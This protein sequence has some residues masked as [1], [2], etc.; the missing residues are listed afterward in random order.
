MSLAANYNAVLTVT[1]ET[2]A[3]TED[4]TP[5]YTES[6]VAVTGW[7][8]ELEVRTVDEPFRDQSIPFSDRRALFMCDAGSD[9]QQDDTGTVVIGG[10]D[11]GWWMV[12]VVRTAPVPSGVGHMEIQLQ[13]TKESK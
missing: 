3:G 1:R 6:T 8:D 4:G 12:S 13:G 7:F 10:I 9:I 2:R 5:V 11:R